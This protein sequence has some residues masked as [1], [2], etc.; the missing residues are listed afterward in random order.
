MNFPPS[1]PITLTKNL[2]DPPLMI[3]P[4]NPCKINIIN[5]HNVQRTIVTRVREYERE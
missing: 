1:Q 5:K 3:A 2:M 4:F